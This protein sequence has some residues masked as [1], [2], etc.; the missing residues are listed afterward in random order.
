MLRALG[1]PLRS[2]ARPCIRRTQAKACCSATS[3]DPREVPSFECVECVDDPLV[4]GGVM[5]AVVQFA[6]AAERKL[7]PCRLWLP[8]FRCL[9]KPLPTCSRLLPGWAE[10]CRHQQLPLCRLS[11]KQSASLKGISLVHPRALTCPPLLRLHDRSLPLTLSRPWCVPALRTSLLL[12]L[13]CLFGLPPKFST[14]S[15]LRDPLDDPCVIPVYAQEAPDEV[16]S[17]ASATPPGKPVT[18]VDFVSASPASTVLVLVP[19][20]LGPSARKATLHD[21]SGPSNPGP[22][23]RKLAAHPSWMT[24][25]RPVRIVRSVSGLP[26]GSRSPASFAMQSVTRLETLGLKLCLRCFCRPKL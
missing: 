23:P 12:L 17:W 24:R 14:V 1:A 25:R 10:S 8:V 4:G 15:N 6:A 7:K 11:L 2:L 26:F 16:K 9:Q 19:R 21:L 22:Q 18:C 3:Q 13:P 5:L 20:A